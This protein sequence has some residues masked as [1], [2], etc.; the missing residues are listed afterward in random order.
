MNKRENPGGCCG[1][2]RAVSGS[3]NYCTGL[4]VIALV[5]AVKALAISGSGRGSDGN[6][7][8]RAL[9]GRQGTN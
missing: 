9:R 3:V 4:V 6:I 2:V 8:S 5:A 7:S 1:S